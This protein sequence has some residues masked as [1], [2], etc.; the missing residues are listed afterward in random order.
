[1]SRNSVGISCLPSSKNQTPLGTIFLF[2]SS[3]ESAAGMAANQWGFCKKI[4]LYGPQRDN[5]FEVILNPSYQPAPDA[6]AQDAW[7]EQVPSFCS[8]LREGCFSIPCCTGKVK[9]WDKILI[10][11]QNING[12]VQEKELSDWPARVW[13][14]ENDHLNGFLY[15]SKEPNKCS[16]FHSFPSR[17]ECL[18]Y[19]ASEQK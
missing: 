14:H 11:Y 2:D 15:D 6:T 9:R 3:R 7:Y 10:K 1:V 12:E 13:Q 4:F 19:R 5:N 17:E 8:L 18:A 16:E